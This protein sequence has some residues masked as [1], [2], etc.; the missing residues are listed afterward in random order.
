MPQ[1]CH[2]RLSATLAVALLIAGCG[3]TKTP[4]MQQFPAHLWSAGARRDFMMACAVDVPRR[5]RCECAAERVEDAAPSDARLKRL[6]QNLVA[7][8]QIVL[9]AANSRVCTDREEPVKAG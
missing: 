9:S 8:P 5:A 7:F 3:G 6:E 1:A 4:A 2:A